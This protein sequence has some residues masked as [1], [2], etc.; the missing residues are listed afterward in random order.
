M[1]VWKVP[2]PPAIPYE[3]DHL[4]Q[5]RM[6]ID[7]QEKLE[8]SDP[9]DYHMGTTDRMKVKGTPMLSA[10]QITDKYQK[11]NLN[12]LTII[13]EKKAEIRKKKIVMLYKD[14]DAETVN[15]EEAE[16]EELLEAER[17]EKIDRIKG[18]K[19]RGQEFTSEQKKARK[20]AIKE[21]KGERKTKKEKFKAK[22]L[23]KTKGATEKN[24]QQTKDGDMQ[25][26]SVM[27][28]AQLK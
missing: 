23:E 6:D 17:L 13:K 7:K 25:G 5:K 8:D 9:E 27:K 15:A 4:A 11:V 18:L 1:K 28:L 19:R 21:L 14:V 16:A 24:H 3:E 2:H 10:E 12:G 26:V 22:F 20:D